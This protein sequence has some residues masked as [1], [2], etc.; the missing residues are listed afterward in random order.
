MK[1]LPYFFLLFIVVSSC[2]QGGYGTASETVNEQSD[3]SRLYAKVME[4]HDAAMPRMTEIN[5]LNAKLAAFKA[6]IPPN[7]EEVVETPQGFELI[8][9]ELKSADQGMWDWMKH[10]GEAKKAT[11]P[12]DLL[13][14]YQEELVKVEK[15]KMD[16][17]SS[18]ARAE[19]WIE[20][21][22]PVK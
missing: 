4:I 13:T 17:D 9:S 22:I 3:T 11:S 5:K 19:V 8:Y 6:S 7:S 16:I 2:K 15:V 12:K 20:K 10:F 1:I 14:F 21:N 18:I